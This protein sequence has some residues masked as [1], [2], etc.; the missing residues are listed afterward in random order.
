MIKLQ[1][2]AHNFDQTPKQNQY[3]MEKIGQLDKYLPRHWREAKG[4]VTLSADHNGH[5]DNRYVCEAVIEVPGATLS[6]KEA[7]SN[8]FAAIDIVEAKLKSQITKHK[9][10]NSPRDSRARKLVDKLFGRSE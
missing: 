8:M 4:T 2:S 10:K 1:V 3:V 9:Q 5:E 6:A 7:T